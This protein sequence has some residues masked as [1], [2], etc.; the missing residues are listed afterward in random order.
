MIINDAFDHLKESETGKYD[1][2]LCDTTDPQ[3]K[4]SST[5]H[6]EYATVKSDTLFYAILFSSFS[7]WKNA[8]NIQLNLEFSNPSKTE[9]VVRKIRGSK[10]QNE[11]V[12]SR[13][14]EKSN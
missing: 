7:C 3:G 12:R 2:I 4:N 6:T 13:P 8:L 11:R 1:V 10:K 14:H 5:P 9:K